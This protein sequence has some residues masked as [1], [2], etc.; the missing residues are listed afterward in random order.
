M[1][2]LLNETAFLGGCPVITRDGIYVEGQR[3]IRL[4]LEGLSP[5][6]RRV[7]VGDVGDLLAYRQEWEPYIAAHLG[8]W[9]YLNGLLESVPDVQ[10]CPSGIFDPSAIK[11]LDATSQAFCA[12]L[13]LTRIRISDSNAG[14]ILQQWNAWKDKSSADMVA[15]AD[16]M[17]K[18]LQDTVM[19]VGGTYKDELLQ[20][21]RLWNVTVQLP[22]VPTFTKQQEIIARIEG[23]YVTTKG[24][25]QL[26]GYGLGETLDAATDQAQAVAKGL[27]ETAKGVS[28]AITSPWTWIGV[29]A[30]VALVGAGLIVYYVPRRSAPA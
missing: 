4:G 23:A 5:R 29:S 24:V 25:L 17:L 2:P 19:R 13:D 18:W 3:V 7:G 20:I 6:A 22:E 30:V 14:G 28:K 27:S 8:L 21:A 9:R 26:L 1:R 15:G 12:S 11:T 16:S 10:K